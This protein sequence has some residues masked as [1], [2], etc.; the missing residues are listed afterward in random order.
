MPTSSALSARVALQ[1]THS[2]LRRSHDSVYAC[3]TRVHILIDIGCT[4]ETRKTSCVAATIVI[5]HVMHFTHEFRRRVLMCCAF[6]R[7]GRMCCYTCSP[8]PGHN[9][10]ELINAPCSACR[11]GFLVFNST[12]ITNENTVAFA[13]A[14]PCIVRKTRQ[15]HATQL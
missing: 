8:F 9:R 15:E 5:F 2:I 10:K 7:V 4:R 12:P 3:T 11:L 13:P 14:C 6:R 1:M